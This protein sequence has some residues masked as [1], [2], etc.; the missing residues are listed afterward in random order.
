M[1]SVR[2]LLCDGIKKEFVKDSLSAET[3]GGIYS[4]Y[5]CEKPL[6]DACLHSATLLFITPAF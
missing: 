3:N 4:V 2:I 5:R 6:S 1:D